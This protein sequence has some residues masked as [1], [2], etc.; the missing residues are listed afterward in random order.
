MIAQKFSMDELM[1]FTEPQ[2]TQLT[3]VLQGFEAYC[4]VSMNDW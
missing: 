3:I 2:N 4:N 1:I